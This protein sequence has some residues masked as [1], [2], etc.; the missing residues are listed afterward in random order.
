MGEIVRSIPDLVRLCRSLV[1]DPTIPMGVR[2]A[3]V[4]VVLYVINPIDL[5][6]EFIPVIGPL[7]DIIVAVLVLRYVRGRLGIETLSRR[8]PGTPEG[9]AALASVLG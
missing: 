9:F 8:W 1:A 2:I 3:L 4:G 6:P 5:I 7:D